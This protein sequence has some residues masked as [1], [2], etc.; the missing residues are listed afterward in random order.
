MTLLNADN[1]DAAERVDQ[2]EPV[3]IIP[4]LLHHPNSVCY[5]PIP[6]IA[7]AIERVGNYGVRTVLE[8]RRGARDAGIRK[9]P[10]C[11]LDR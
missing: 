5:H 6:S 9:A 10:E 3:T 4:V 1:A 8:D 7:R 11:S 2:S